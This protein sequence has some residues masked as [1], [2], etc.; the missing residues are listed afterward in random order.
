MAGYNNVLALWLSSEENL[1]P[2]ALPLIREQDGA[3]VQRMKKHYVA[4]F[5]HKN[6]RS[7]VASV[8]PANLF[9]R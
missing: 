6:V 1:Y 2:S 9:A 4:Q 7:V 3:H 5:F 8:Y